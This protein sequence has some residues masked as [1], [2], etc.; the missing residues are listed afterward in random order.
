MMIYIYIYT[1]I[2]IYIHIHTLYYSYTSNVVF[3]SKI[4]WEE[5]E[6]VTVAAA[7]R[8]SFIERCSFINLLKADSHIS[9]KFVLFA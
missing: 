3:N 5:G 7:M 1:Y 6:N 9:K 4:M 8:A 2:Y